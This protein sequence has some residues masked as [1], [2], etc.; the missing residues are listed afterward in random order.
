MKHSKSDAIN[1]LEN[2]FTS[3]IEYINDDSIVEIIAASS[4][5]LMM[6]GYSIS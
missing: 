4:D 6:L 2:A 5:I 3:L 1:R